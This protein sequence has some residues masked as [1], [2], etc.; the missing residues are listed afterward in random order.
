M[1]R[2]ASTK[3]MVKYTSYII[4]KKLKYLQGTAIKFWIIFDHLMGLIEIGFLCAEVKYF[5]RTVR[6]TFNQMN[7]YSYNVLLLYQMKHMY[8]FSKM[9]RYA[10]AKSMVT[11][12]NY[13]I[14]NL[15][16]FKVLQKN[17]GFYLN[18]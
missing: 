3:S 12:T 8:I 4:E 7:E 6:V 2:Y 15:N 18:F 13:I 11:H 5:I 9:C 1:C 10:S 16:I 14:K 17:F